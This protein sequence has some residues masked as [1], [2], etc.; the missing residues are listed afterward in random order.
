[1]RKLDH[2]RQI[3]ILS[4]AQALRMDLVK[5]GTG[6]YALRV[7]REITSLSIS[8]KW[9]RWKRW[10]GKTS[11]GVSEGST[12]DLVMHMRDCTFQDAVQF[13]TTRFS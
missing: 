5:V 6:T 9:N 1:M 3:S 4:V 2:L 11:G 12:I 7:E 10:S 13:L 8:E